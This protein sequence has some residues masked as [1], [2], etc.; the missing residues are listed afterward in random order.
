MHFSGNLLQKQNNMFHFY[1][2]INFYCEIYFNV[3]IELKTIFNIENDHCQINCYFK[4]TKY[5]HILNKFS[6]IIGKKIFAKI[7]IMLKLWF[8]NII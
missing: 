6:Q 7:N 4:N 8:N 2:E 1:F 3:G 5:T